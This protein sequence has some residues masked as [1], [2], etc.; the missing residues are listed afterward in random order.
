MRTARLETFS[1]GV[2]AIAA[3]LLILD[4]RA[5]GSPLGEELRHIWPSYVAYA[6]SFITIGIIWVNHHV[7]MD[8]IARVDRRFLFI[9]VFFLMVV[10]FIPFPTEL[11]AHYIRD[12]GDDARA[13]VLAYGFTFTLMGVAFGGMWWYAAGGKRLLKPDADPRTVA[14]ITRSFRPG[15]L[16]YLGATLLAFASPVASLCVFGALALAYV[17]ESGIFVRN[18]GRE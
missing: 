5:D 11:V 13:A 12:G 10:A 6:I 9:N 3:T 8:Q 17:V 7:V 2:I 1:D 16:V 18:D 15:S 14:G 4:V